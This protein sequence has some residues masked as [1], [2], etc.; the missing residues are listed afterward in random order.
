MFNSNIDE[1]KPK[2]EMKSKDN[3]YHPIAGEDFWLL[4]NVTSY[5]D[6]DIYW[7]RSRDGKKYDLLTRCFARSKICKKN[8]GIKENITSTSFEIK[9]LKFPE[10]DAYYKCNASNAYGNFSEVFHLQI[11][12]N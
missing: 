2:I 10:D 5:P 8:E 7:W 4:Y 3:N 1:R 12:G 6:S 9:N 11:Y